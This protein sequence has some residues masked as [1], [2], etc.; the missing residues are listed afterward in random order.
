MS[1]FISI[2]WISTGIAML[3]IFSILLS[4]LFFPIIEKI[5]EEDEDE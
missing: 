5:S 3:I 2:I 4:A 1:L